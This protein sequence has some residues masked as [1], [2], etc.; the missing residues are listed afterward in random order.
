MPIRCSRHLVLDVATAA[1]VAVAGL[2]LV[3][4]RLLPALAERARLDPGERV[5]ADLGFRRIPA[6]DTVGVTDAEPSL[7]VVFKSTCPV[8]EETA[9]T[10]RALTRRAP[11]RVFAVGLESDS[12][13]VAWVRDKLAPVGA[14]RPLQPAAFLDRLRIRAVPTTLLFEGRRLVLARIGPLQPDDLARIGRALDGT[15][16]PELADSRQPPPRRTP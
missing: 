4:D 7:V 1:L 8:C 5:D 12:A 9:P 14:V 11:H 3:H 13:A 15:R 6:G 2:L 16:G 10:W